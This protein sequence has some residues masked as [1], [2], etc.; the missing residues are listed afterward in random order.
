MQVKAAVAWAA[1]K[2]LSI[3]TV[4]LAGPRAGE[5]FIAFVIL[6]AATATPIFPSTVVGSPCPVTAA[7]VTP[8]SVDL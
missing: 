8:P 7:Q 4:D 1:G 5:P 3:E 6:T 2:P